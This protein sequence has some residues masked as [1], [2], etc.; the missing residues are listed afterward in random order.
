[1]TVRVEYYTPTKAP[2]DKIFVFKLGKFE[3]ETLVIA[4]EALIFET[5]FYNPMSPPN[6]IYYCIVFKI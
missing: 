5:P 2:N 6:I 1:V 4:A 3:N